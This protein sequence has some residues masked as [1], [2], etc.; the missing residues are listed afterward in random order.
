MFLGVNL[1]SREGN[2]QPGDSSLF[3]PGDTLLAEDRFLSLLWNQSRE[4]ILD[5]RL[6]YGSSSKHYDWLESLE[7]SSHFGSKV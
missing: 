5:L 2:S 6:H 4:E 1:L 7:F 3:L